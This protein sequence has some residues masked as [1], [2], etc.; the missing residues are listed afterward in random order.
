MS[1]SGP[2]IWRVPA[3]V[4]PPPET[5][6]QIIRD[7]MTA[8]GT[9]GAAAAAVYFGA[10]RDRLRTPSLSLHFDSDNPFDRQLVGARHILGPGG[11]VLGPPMDQAWLRLRVHNKPRRVAGEDVTVHVT[12]VR[13]LQ[14]R[15]NASAVTPRSPGGLPLIW[16][17]SDG[18]TS[19]FVP[20][21][22]D[23]AI[24]FGYIDR[25]AAGSTGNAP[26]ILV[27]N[28]VPMDN[29]QMLTSLRVEVGLTVTARN[30]EPRHYRVVVFCDGR[31]GDDPWAHLAIESLSPAR[32]RR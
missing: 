24:D 8:V 10:I 29:R 27:V 16:S 6:W 4:I 20:P 25:S 18:R 12:D 26:L 7:W 31:W 5:T 13:E 9:I 28:P 3:P 22:A 23:V 30:T 21:G 19:G 17:N 11:P 15:P 32:L 14:A 1:G 2:R